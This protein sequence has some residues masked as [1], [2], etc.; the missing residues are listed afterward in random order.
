[1]AQVESGKKRLRWKIGSFLVAVFMLLYVPS[2]LHWVFGTNIQSDLL[3]MGTIEDSTNIDAVLIRDEVILTSPFDGKCIVEADEGEKVAA[4]SPVATVLKESS[5]QLMEDLKKLDGRII[6]AQNE[7]TKNQ[8]LFSEDVTRIKLNIEEKLT[9]VIS[10]VQKDT[11]E[12]IPRLT[13]DINDLVRKRAMIAGS[14]STP[15]TFI[16][17]LKNDRITLEQKIRQSTQEITSEHA[18][19]ISYFTDQYE[20]M[21]TP[22]AIS[23]LTPEQLANIKTDVQVKSMTG[24]QVYAGKPFAKIIQDIVYYSA[25]VLEENALG[26]LQTGSKIKVRI[27]DVN[28]VADAVVT[29]ISQPQQGKCVIAVSMDKALHETAALRKVNIDIIRSSYTGLK[30]PVKS[31]R[32]YNTADKSA[33][34]ALITSGFASIRKVKVLGTNNEYAVVESA[35]KTGKGVNIYDAFILHPENIQEGQRIDQ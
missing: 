15:D 31:L 35:N 21:L 29:Y 30:I 5:E 23:T 14:L 17:S 10:E 6:Q 34:V 19:I 4:K 13:K 24:L 25:F 11:L 26:E 12:D 8:E 18:G 9:Q 7:K 16:D 2:L 28:K 27:N 32:N 33:E 20:N 3:Q 22:A 1:M